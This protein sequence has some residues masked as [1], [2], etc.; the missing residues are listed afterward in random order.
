LAAIE[1]LSDTL[2]TV[3]TLGDMVENAN[4][5][6]TKINVMEIQKMDFDRSATFCGIPLSDTF[7]KVD[8]M[9][10]AISPYS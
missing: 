3:D 4:S 8:W 10:I 1:L 2:L 5:P 7:V 6:I 9:F